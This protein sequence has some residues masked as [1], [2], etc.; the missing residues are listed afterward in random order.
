VDV[1]VNYCGKPYRMLRTLESLL[2]HSGR[3]IDA[4]YLICE[5]R[6]PRS[7]EDMGVLTRRLGS[8]L[9]VH[10]VAQYFGWNAR[11]LL[12]VRRDAERRRSVRY[13]Y[14]LEETDKPYVFVTHNDVVYHA[15]LVGELVRVLDAG[16][17]AGA[18]AVGQCW[19][20][21][22]C[23]AG[24]CDGTRNARLRLTSVQAL[25]LSVR[26]RSPRTRPWR[27]HP[28]RPVPLP[29]CRL[30]EFA[31]LLDVGAYRQDTMPWGSAPPLGFYG[32]ELDL[33]CAWFRAMVAGGHA[34]AHVPITD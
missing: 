9:R 21:P 29:E 30:N 24:L 34:F 7:D 10:T 23:T 2:E 3:H 4:I 5:P 15:D 25:L 19:N 12:R 28:R 31:C 32:W 1:A 18:G 13:Q 11:S 8:R 33:G 17:Y 20:C 6:Q 16:S 26:V 14:A 22:A 27:I